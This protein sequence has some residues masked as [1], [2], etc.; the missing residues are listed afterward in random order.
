VCERALEAFDGWLAA[1]GH[2]AAELRS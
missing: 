1:I 2:P